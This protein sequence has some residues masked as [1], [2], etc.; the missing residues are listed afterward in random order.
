MARSI[1]AKKRG[2]GRAAAPRTLSLEC[3]GVFGHLAAFSELLSCYQ[4]RVREDENAEQ[5]AASRS[6]VRST[7]SFWADTE[8]PMAL[9]KFIELSGLSAVTLYRFRKRGFLKT[10]NICGR[11][12]VARSE[13][14]RF[15][16][17]AAAGEFAKQIVPPCQARRKC[18][19]GARMGK[20]KPR[21]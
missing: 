20:A 16:A 14:A 18:S 1:L 3:S 5:V 8:P 15:N 7:S 12:Y 13:I 10:I 17:R 6:E 11:H 4:F 9:D 21:L 19:S 2:Y